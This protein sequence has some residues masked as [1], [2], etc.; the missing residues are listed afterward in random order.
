MDFANFFKRQKKTGTT[1]ALDIGTY[2]IKTLE[3][4]IAS[5][6]TAE[7]LKFGS[8]KIGAGASAEERAG[9]IKGLFEKNG[10]TAEVV[11]V[12]VAGPKTITRFINLP[13]MTED[14]LKQSLEFEA[15]RYIPF[16]IKEVYLDCDILDTEKS[17]NKVRVL[18]AA[19]KKELINEKLEVLKA[20]ELFPAVMDMDCTALT[21]AFTHTQKQE[22]GEICALLNVGHS[23]TQ[24][25]ITRK[26]ML[27]FVR[28]LQ[29]GG[30]DLS[31]EKFLNQVR[32]SFDYYENQVG[33]SVDKIYISGGAS[34]I[35]NF[36][37][38]L[39]DALDIDTVCWDPFS[40]MK[41]GEGL[42]ED[43]L[44]EAAPL[45]AVAVG[46]ALR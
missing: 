34:K 39:K 26:G 19:S 11:N 31:L 7:V 16:E 18:V 12:S 43:E 23:L 1:V 35:E 2:S 8:E 28:E 40:S 10:I 9:V 29:I 33:K 4:K 44:R 42:K 22:E 6:G 21:N 3:V 25:A 15:E 27:D 17:G 37:T 20:A 36:N 24:T 46:L 32:L 41:R 13:K 38:Q 30:A 14:E 5:D 45:F